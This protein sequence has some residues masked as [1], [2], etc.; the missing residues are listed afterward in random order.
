MLDPNEL[1]RVACED[2][3][4]FSNG[5]KLTRERWVVDQWLLACGLVGSAVQPGGDPPDFLVDG[6]GIE[7][8]ELMEPNRRRGDQYNAR[9]QA[10]HAGH[11]LPRKL[12]PRSRV[13]E[14]GHEWVLG[15][16]RRKAARYDASSSAAWTLL[17]YVNLPYADC[18][19]WGQVEATL[20]AQAPRFNRVEVVF[21]VG[22]GPTAGKVYVHG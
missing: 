21:D 4:F 10:A 5:Q 15:A 6:R 8:V 9:L 19:S 2:R 1:L 22:R 13:V 16:I 14:Q 3:A 11:T 20:D 12:S 7:V 18:L 17:L